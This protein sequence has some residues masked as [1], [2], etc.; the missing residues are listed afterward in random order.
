MGMK[1]LQC[2]KCGE[3]MTDEQVTKACAT[4]L[5]MQD[6]A[7]TAALQ[8]RVDQE[9]R[10]RMIVNPNEVDRVRQELNRT[11]A[12]LAEAEAKLAEIRP[13]YRRLFGP[14]LPPWDAP[15]RA[16]DDYDEDDDDL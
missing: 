8:A 9:V 2:R 11:K 7:W 1:Y 3:L 16:V 4:Y 15:G 5:E 6:A 10:V 12:R 14:K 13:W